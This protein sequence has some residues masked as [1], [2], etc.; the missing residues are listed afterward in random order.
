M[1][2]GSVSLRSLRRTRLKKEGLRGLGEEKD[3]SEEKSSLRRLWKKEKSKKLGKDEW[4][5]ALIEALEEEEANFEGRR[6]A[7]LLEKADAAAKAAAV[8][9][10]WAV[11]QE[12]WM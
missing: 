12:T 4:L 10:A 1:N 6:L 8:D 9:D 11:G 3:Y 2:A 7:A 5:P